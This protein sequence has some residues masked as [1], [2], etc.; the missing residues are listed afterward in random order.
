MSKLREQLEKALELAGSTH[1][2]DDLSDRIDAGQA[3]AWTEGDSVLIAEVLAFPQHLVANFWIAAGDLETLRR[4]A[5]RAEKH[6]R[7]LGCTRATFTGRRGWLRSPLVTEDG[8][9]PILQT[10]QKEL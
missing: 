1:T 8:W 4:I 3:K 6:Y 2:L 10:F 5:R 7:E 9:R